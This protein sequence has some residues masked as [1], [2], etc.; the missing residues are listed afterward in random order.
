MTRPICVGVRQEAGERLH[1]AREHQPFVVVQRVPRRH[2]IRTRRQLGVRREEAA[3]LLAGERLVAPRVPAAVEPPPVPLDERGRRLVGGVAGA[4][5]EV[6]EPWLVD[7]DVAQ[8]LDE[9]DG[10]VG[11]ILGEV[12]AVV[13][14]RRRVDVVV[15]GDERGREL[16][17]L[18]TEEAVEALEAATDRPAVAPSTEVLLVLRREVPLA[19]R[20]RRVPVRRQHRREEPA[21]ARD[22]GVVAREAARQFDD[23]THAARVVVATGQHARASRRA[24]R[25]GVEVGVPQAVRGEAVERRRLDVRTEAAQLGEADVVE[26]HEQHVGRT[27]RRPGLVGPPRLRLPVV[28]TDPP[29]ELARLHVLSIAV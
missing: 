23:A 22:A 26:Q 5:R 16:V 12:V 17:G 8:V 4:R 9:L 3:R 13:E 7:V 11:Q 10:P 1:V 29:A 18:A 24:Q 6:Q 25:G 19:D 21:R 15:V 27:R 2:P 14:A 20:V 28:P